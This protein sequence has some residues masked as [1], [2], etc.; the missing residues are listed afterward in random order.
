MTT[1]V[2]LELVGGFADACFAIRL[3]S[4]S[5]PSPRDSLLA[6]LLPLKPALLS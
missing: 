1:A 2:L 6:P 3:A 4:E 5:L